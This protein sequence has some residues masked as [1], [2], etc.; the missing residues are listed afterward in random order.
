MK[1]NVSYIPRRSSNRSLTVLF[2]PA[3]KEMTE[4]QEL[5]LM[6]LDIREELLEN[7]YKEYTKKNLE[8]QSAKFVVN[9]AHDAWK[10]LV[11][12]N[13]L[14]HN[15]Q[16][17]GNNIYWV[18]DSE[19]VICKPDSW[20]RANLKLNMKGNPREMFQQT[21]DDPDYI[22]ESVPY[23]TSNVYEPP[24]KENDLV[25][26]PEDEIVCN[27]I[28]TVSSEL[29][30]MKANTPQSIVQFSDPTFTNTSERMSASIA[31]VICGSK[32]Y[33]IYS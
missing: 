21:D 9:C 23:P 10:K 16:N 29:R 17:L 5:L 12:L 20:S 26:V 27:P 11:N 1:T 8:K 3:W 18:P 4:H 6:I 30:N 25:A 32:S 7:I 33:F 13:F 31:H 24:L 15:F 19:L 28:A 2:D 22:I 14:H